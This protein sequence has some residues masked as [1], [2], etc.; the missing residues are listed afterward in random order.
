MRILQ[1]RDTEPASFVGDDIRNQGL[2]AMHSFLFFK[3]KNILIYLA[4]P[5]LSGGMW[6]LKFQ[7]ADF[8]RPACGI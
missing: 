2:G 4:A 5:A 7:R 8:L 3:L 1:G 6:D